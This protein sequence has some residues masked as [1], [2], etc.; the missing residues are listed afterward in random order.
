MNV[1][2]QDR[3]YARAVEDTLLAEGVFSSHND[4]PGGRTIY[5]ITERDYPAW[6]KK[7]YDLHGAGRIDDAIAAAKEFYFE[8][9]WLRLRC[10]DIESCAVAREL[11][12]SAVNCGRGTAVRILQRAVN[13]FNRAKGRPEIKEDGKIGAITIAATMGWAR[14]YEL[15]LLVAMNYYQASYYERLFVDN[16]RLFDKFMIGWLRRCVVNV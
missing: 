13:L 9:F 11:F 16:P 8:E 4:D 6:F 2:T 5:G 12:D 7:C 15:Q 1:W 14:Q 3:C 10:P